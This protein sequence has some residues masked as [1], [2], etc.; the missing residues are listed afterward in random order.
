[1]Q[2]MRVDQAATEAKAADVHA[3]IQKLEADNLRLQL[4][5]KAEHEKKQGVN[6][7]SHVLTCPEGLAAW[8]Q[9]Q[10]EVATCKAEKAAK[11]LEKDMAKHVHTTVSTKLFCK[12]S[13]SR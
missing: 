10:A 6:I 11:T 8:E 7:E 2:V 3:T 5:L 4:P 13:T 12:Y 1:M 9:Y